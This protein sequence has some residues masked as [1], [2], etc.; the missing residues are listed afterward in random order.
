MADTKISALTAYTTPL[1]ADEIAIVDKANGLTKR[2]T[3]G[4]LNKPPMGEISY[5]SLTGTAVTIASQSD[6]STNMVVV[7]V[8][9]ALSSSFEFDNGGSNNGRLRY[10]GTDTKMFHIAC[11]ISF[12][13]GPTDTFVIGIARSG[14]V[15]SACK[16]LRKMGAGGDVGS[17]AIHCMVTLA[18]NQYLELYVGNTSATNNPTFHT[19]NLFAMGMY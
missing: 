13:G 15:V 2:I 11:S 18:T 19:L 1:T 10:T 5:F 12:S 14:T 9:T 16:A 6:G 17:T 4:D 7:P 8:V 3:W